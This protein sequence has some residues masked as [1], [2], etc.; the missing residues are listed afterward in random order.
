MEHISLH[1]LALMIPPLAATWP[2]KLARVFRDLVARCMLSWSRVTESR[3]PAAVIAPRKKM[4]KSGHGFFVHDPPFGPKLCNALSNSPPPRFFDWFRPGGCTLH[5]IRAIRAIFGIRARGAG[6]ACSCFMTN[7]IKHHI[8]IEWNDACRS[9]SMTNSRPFERL[10]ANDW[11][12]TRNSSLPNS[13]SPM[14]TALLTAS[15]W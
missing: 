14:R 4:L 3:V 7:D 2:P 5:E 12:A 8:R 15:A 6:R 13:V 1:W 10:I 11:N 9:E